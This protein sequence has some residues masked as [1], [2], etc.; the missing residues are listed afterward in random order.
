LKKNHPELLE[1]RQYVL[2]EFVR[3]DINAIIERLQK[4]PDVFPKLRDF[5]YDNY[6]KAQGVKAGIKS[7][8]QFIQLAYSY[9]KKNGIFYKNL[10]K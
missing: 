9:Q 7:Y 1:E 3:T 6:L 2:P 8:G 10:I 4:Y 5:F